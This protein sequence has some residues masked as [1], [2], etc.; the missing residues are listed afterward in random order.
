[1]PRTLNINHLFAAFKA[2]HLLSA[3]P[4]EAPFTAKFDLAPWV[5]RV[6]G[7]LSYYLTDLD[8]GCGR[9]RRCENG[10]MHVPMYGYATPF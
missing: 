7:G 3:P 5:T 9:Q 8:R 1:M 6:T 4:F 10:V 2:R